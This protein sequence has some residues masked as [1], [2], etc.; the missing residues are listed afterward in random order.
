M[1]RVWRIVPAA[2]FPAADEDYFADMDG[3][4]KLSPEEV[5]GRN[6]WIVWSGGND[7]FWDDISKRQLR[8][9]RFSEDAFLASESEIQPRYIAGTILDWSM[10]RAL[11]RLPD[12][13]E[14]LRTLARQA[15][16]PVLIARQTLSKMKR[17][18]LA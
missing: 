8:H 18:T 5:K 16:R 15:H 17:N 11:K 13:S 10:S 12:R 14:P 1:R 3:G 9:A 2:S 6:T 4:A 7:R